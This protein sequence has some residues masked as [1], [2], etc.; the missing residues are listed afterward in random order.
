ML[1]R[2]ISFEH[3]QNKNTTTLMNIKDMLQTI[4]DGG[5]NKFTDGGAAASSSINQQPWSFQ[6]IT[7]EEDLVFFEQRISTDSD[8]EFRRIYL[9]EKLLE[10]IGPKPNTDAS[11]QNHRIIFQK[12]FW[13]GTAWTGGKA[14]ANNNHSQP[15]ETGGG[16]Q[17][18][19]TQQVALRKF[20]FCKHVIFIDFFNQTIKAITGGIMSDADM[21]KFVQ[22]RCRNSF[23]E[24]TSNRAPAHRSSSAKK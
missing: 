8:P 18:T 19:D 16:S 1:T 20:A 15:S 2:L 13:A 5:A 24:P 3:I 12:S 9:I 14:A 6:K 11:R 10:K 22:G 23:Y 17:V 7:S 4:L 21:K